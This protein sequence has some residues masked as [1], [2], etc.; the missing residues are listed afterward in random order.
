MKTPPR[1]HGF[2]YK[3]QG[4]YFLTIC[5]Y[6]RSCLFGRIVDFRVC[7]SEVG[8]VISEC[9][10]NLGNIYG[11][12]ELDAFVVMPNHFHGILWITGENTLKKPLSRIIAGFK[13]ASTS[14]ARSLGNSNIRIWQRNFYEHVI[15]S[16]KE[17]LNVREYVAN[18]PTNWANDPENPSYMGSDVFPFDKYDD[19]RTP[20]WLGP[21]VVC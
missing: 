2:D 13:A 12:V 14:R 3:Q 15:R 8:R 18:N 1:L 19:V 11:F 17:L 4:A 9:W 16:D 6:Q 20:S 7:E 10:M 5:S 21:E